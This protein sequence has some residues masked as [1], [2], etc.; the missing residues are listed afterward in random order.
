MM[1]I[2]KVVKSQ[3]VTLFNLYSQTLTVDISKGD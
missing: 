2:V 1:E 3:N